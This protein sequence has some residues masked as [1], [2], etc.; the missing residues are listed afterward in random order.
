MVKKTILRVLTLKKMMMEGYLTPQLGGAETISAELNDEGI[1]SSK[2]R[3]PTLQGLR[4]LGSLLLGS[5]VKP[6]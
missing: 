6:P 5:K 4:P 2:E 1:D 3:I